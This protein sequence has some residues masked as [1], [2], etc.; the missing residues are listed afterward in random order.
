MNNLALDDKRALNII[1][2]ASDD[3]SI[4][5]Q[6]KAYDEKGQADIYWNYIIGAV[7]KYYDYTL[8]RAFFNY[9][10]TDSQHEFYEKLFWLGLEKCAFDKGKK[11]RPVLHSL[12]KNYAK[13]VLA[14]E[15]EVYNDN[16]LNVLVNAH[17]KR[18][19]GKPS[20]IGGNAL[21]ILMDLD[22]GDASTEEIVSKM[23]RIIKK[24]FR[25]NFG[26]YEVNAEKSKIRPQKQI[27]YGD[28]EKL[29]EYDLETMKTLYLDSAETTRDVYYEELKEKVKKPV[30]K[31][32]TEK[33]DDSE[34][35]YIR[36]YFGA[37]IISRKKTHLLERTHCTGNHKNTHLHFTRGEFDQEFEGDSNALYYHKALKE[38]REINL[39]HFN[40]NYIRYK[41]SIIKLTNKIKNTMLAYFESYTGKSQAGRLNT[42]KIWRNVYLK[43]DRVFTK[44]Y[45]NDIGNLSVDILLDASASQ[46]E[47]QE[48]IAAEAYIIAEAFTRCDIPVK[49]YSFS[50]LRN[51]TV[52]NLYRDYEETD[53]N[54]EI[55]NYKTT[56]CNRDGL[57]IR[58]ALHMM[59]GSGYFNK[60]L[61]VLSDCKPN[62]TQCIPDTGIK[63]EQTKYARA[64]GII[65]TAFEVKKGINNGS[66]ILCV[67]TGEDEDLPTAKKIYGHN[68]A[69][70]YNPDRF[71]EIVGVLMQNQLKN[72]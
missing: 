72:L 46:H 12:R 43:D 14:G 64:T 39:D 26:R 20:G 70:I 69:R 58:T 54:N 32:K 42:P 53:K 60:I 52:I 61:I 47:R 1:W 59:E 18:A 51:F 62:D 34:R 33:K 16:L 13:K 9:L 65:D 5:P 38:Q 10:K 36:K 17:F 29:S 30:K 27:Q 48:T 15:T 4:E 67:F 35:L 50:S 63:Q 19:L 41:N 11:E 31:V 44:V 68:F 7:H 22:F 55:F 49:V 28:E 25:F 71:A 66:S 3:Y 56:G 21:N 6:F 2:N 37:S 45:N 57:A 8:L 23:N 40:S 24:Y